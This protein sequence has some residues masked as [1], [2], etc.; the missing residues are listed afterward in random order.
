MIWSGLPLSVEEA[1]AQFDVDEV[2]YTT[3][4]NA[5]LAHLATTTDS[6]PTTVFAIANQVSDHITFL[7]FDHKNFD[8]LKEA[9]ET[10][11][12]VKDEYEIALLAKAN[13][14]SS[15]AHAAVL[16]RVKHV[17]NEQ[18]LEATFLAECI[19][20]GAKHQAYHSI[21]AGGRA[22]ATLHYVKNDA[23]VAGK[24]NL[25][26]DAGAEWGV[27]CADIVSMRTS[28]PPEARRRDES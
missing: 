16:R 20:R 11:R 5:S 21:V 26:L 25:L 18:E 15:A 23:P 22:A 27:Y 6:K 7:E 3:E 9:I 13:A 10:C 2:R 17:A 12:V 4:A 1:L 8:V 28:E 24:W 14:I 19:R